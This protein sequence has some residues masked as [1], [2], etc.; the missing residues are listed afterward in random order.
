MVYYVLKSHL[1]VF[2]AIPNALRTFTGAS[3]PYSQCWPLLF[4]SPFVP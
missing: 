1:R 3:H 4:F 2:G